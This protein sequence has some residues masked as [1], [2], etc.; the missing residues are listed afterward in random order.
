MNTSIPQD[1]KYSQRTQISLSPTLRQQI[2]KLKKPNQSL[3]EFIRQAVELKIN[4]QEQAQTD[5]QDRI[6]AAKSFIGSVKIEDHPEWSTDEKIMNYQRELRR[7]PPGR[8]DRP[9]S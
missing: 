1:Q 4:Q 6:K 8:Y 9:K 7:E 5:L 3:S 2:E